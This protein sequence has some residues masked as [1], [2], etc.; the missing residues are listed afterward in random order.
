LTNG[1]NEQLS[2]VIFGAVLIVLMMVAPGGIM[3]LLRQIKAWL[4]RQF[5]SRA[6]GSPPDTTAPDPAVGFETHAGGQAPD[7]ST[8]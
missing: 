7:G 2:P 3:G 4:L 6:G 1:Y 5:G 8:A